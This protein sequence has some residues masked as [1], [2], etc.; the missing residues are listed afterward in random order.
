MILN[1]KV[2][3]RLPDA[4]LFDT[5]NTLYN[6]LP[7]HKVAINEVLNKAFKI[8]A[9]SKVDFNN[10]LFEAKKEIK[11]RLGNT[12]SSHNRLLYFQVTLEK[13]GLNSQIMFALD[14]EQTYWRTFLNA[15]S[16]FPNVKELLGDLRKLEIPTAIVTDLTA[17]IQFRKIVYFELDKLFDYIVTSEESGY[18]KPNPSSFKLAIKKMQPKG[19]KIWMIGDNYITDIKGSRDAIDAIA[20]QKKHKGV[21]IESKKHKPDCI[22][23][24]Y[25][26]LRSLINKISTKS[27]KV[28]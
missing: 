22:F 16:L 1:K 28:N 27:I 7:A 4:V 12:A 13:L 25:S 20:I 15:S 5:D 26:E 24:N 6:Y 14:L 17:Q 3:D 10:A 9:I 2:F 18:D 11:D 21:I 8:F 19:S 23:E